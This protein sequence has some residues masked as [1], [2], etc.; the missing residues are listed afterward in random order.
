MLLQIAGNNIPEDICEAIGKFRIFFFLNNL[1][2]L[3]LN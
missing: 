3:N 1:E 2:N